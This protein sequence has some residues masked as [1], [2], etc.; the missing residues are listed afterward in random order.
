MGIASL[1]IKSFRN[2]K[3]SVGLAIASITLSVAL[4]LGVEILRNEAR[5]SFT[6]AVSGTDLIVGARGSPVNLL[7]YS[8]FRIGNPTNNIEWSSYSQIREIP[9]VKWSIPL[10]MGDSH[11]GYRVLGTDENYLLHYRYADDRSLELREGEWFRQQYEIVL[12]A[13]VAE[14]L[15]YQL[16]DRVVVAHGAGDVSFVTHADR[17]F[18]VVG[19]L[20][21][22]ATPVDRTLHV[23]LAGF[24]A[25]HADW[26]NSDDSHAHSPLPAILPEIDHR[27]AARDSDAHQANHGDH[28]ERADHDHA[29]GNGNQAATSTDHEIERSISAFL[30]GLDSRST[31]LGMMRRINRYEQEPL[32]AIMPGVTLLELWEIT[33]VVERL[34]VAISALVVAMALFSMLIILLA[35]SNERRREMAVL[36]AIGAR[37][38]HVFALALGEAAFITLAG[39]LLGVAS[40]EGVLVFGQEWFGHRFGLNVRLDLLS[41]HTVYLLSIVA[42]VGC[43]AGLIPALR[44]YRYSL[45]DGMT[46]RV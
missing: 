9:G 15:D 44:L 40:V 11:R 33:A 22:T 45:I 46:V 27:D 13:E 26:G 34:L 19:I 6:N 30:L 5:T 18:R 20:A 36:R 32:S 8:V 25:L 23:S 31:A 37:P 12:G 38:G 7:L 3:F 16:D 42:T 28:N 41:A 4:L 29:A 2:R 1:A 17:P 35:S 24:D 21:P 39:I 43:M 10:S 14:R